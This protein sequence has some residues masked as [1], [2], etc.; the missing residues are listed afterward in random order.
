MSSFYEFYKKV[1]QERHIHENTPGVP[2]TPAPATGQAQGTAPPANDKALEGIMK[3]WPDILKLVPRI[4]DPKLKKAFEELVKNYPQLS[5]QPAAAPKQAG[6]QPPQPQAGQQP[7]QPQA[8]QQ[9]A[10]AGQQPPQPQAG[11]QPPQ[12]QK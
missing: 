4:Q 10:P 8:G 5:G 11:Q 12:P 3:F 6:Q 7:P 9:P 2:A 1:S